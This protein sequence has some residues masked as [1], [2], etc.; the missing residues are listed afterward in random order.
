MAFC[1][2][3][4][5]ALTDGAGFCASCGKQVGGAPQ[6]V[7]SGPQ[8]G[9]AV[10]PA[11]SSALASN[12]AAALSYVLGLIT[13]I[14]FLVLEPYKR[15]RFVRFHAMQSILFCAAA[16][17]F[18]IAWSIIWGILFSISGSLIFI[19][20]PLRLVISLGLF[21]FWL[22]VMYQAYSQREYRIPIIGAIAAKQVG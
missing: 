12:A 11:A 6:A 14:I 2:N 8:V 22:F 17:A 20:V 5:A 3:C 21:L 16:I 10:A 9:S 13:G 18:S 4:G 15:D 7:P 1:A 19:D